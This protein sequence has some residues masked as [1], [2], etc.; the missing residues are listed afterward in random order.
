MNKTGFSI[1]GVLFNF[2]YQCFKIFIVFLI[3]GWMDTKVLKYIR[4]NNIAL[5]SSFSAILLF[6]YRN[7]T[8]FCVLILYPLTLLNS[9]IS[10][11][12]GVLGTLHMWGHIICKQYLY[13]LELA[14]R[15]ERQRPHQQ[16]N[17]LWY[18]TMSTQ[19][20]CIGDVVSH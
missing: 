20:Y 6:V 4:H 16:D 9:L 12:A 2:I 19:H 3:L 8:D 17:P 14:F 1:F 5:I 11:L 10:T 18:N 7:V 13:F 15:Y